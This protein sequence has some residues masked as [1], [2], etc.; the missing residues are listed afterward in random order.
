VPVAAAV[1]TL[2]S[3]Q[4]VTSFEAEVK[5]W[6][7]PPAYQVRYNTGHGGPTVDGKTR[8]DVETKKAD[9]DTAVTTLRARTYGGVLQFYHSAYSSKGGGVCDIIFSEDAKNP[10]DRGVKSINYHIK[11]S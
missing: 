4:V 9:F 11:T 7:P 1:V 10:N 6:W 5:S 8:T 3:A 2:T